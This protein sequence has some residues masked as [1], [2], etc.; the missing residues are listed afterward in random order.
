M[1][2]EHWLHVKVTCCVI[3]THK[4]ARLPLEVWSQDDLFPIA[5]G[6]LEGK[7]SHGRVFH[8]HQAAILRANVTRSLEEEVATS[9]NVP[10]ASLSPLILQGQLLSFTS[11]PDLCSLSI[12]LLQQAKLC[13]HFL[14]A[15]A[16]L[17]RMRSQLWI[18]RQDLRECGR[19]DVLHTPLKS[20]PYEQWGHCSLSFLSFVC[21]ERDI[22][23]VLGESLICVY[24]LTYVLA[25][26]AGLSAYP[27]FEHAFVIR[28]THFQ[29][30][31]K[32]R[33]I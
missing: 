1:N 6:V 19:F 28:M 31:V 8:L 27:G 16:R 15:S 13:L 20:S 29:L 33:T 4:K 7:P 10:E 17:C 14:F 9:T 2:I 21:S 26:D 18:K 25:E 23:S 22:F 12:V 3:D 32:A 24:S 30:W 11:G 5:V